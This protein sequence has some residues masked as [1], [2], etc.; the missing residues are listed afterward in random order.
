MCIRD[1]NQTLITASNS[2]T[3]KGDIT[4]EIWK[5]LYHNAPYLLKTKGT[6]RNI[7][8]LL[9]TYGLPST[10]L[11]VFEYGG[12]E[13]DKTKTSYANFD[14]FSHALDF[15]NDAYLKL[16]FEKIDTTHPFVSVGTTKRHPDVLEM[17]FN[18]SNKNKQYLFSRQ[19]KFGVCIEP[20]TSA[21][22][23]DSGYYNHAKIAVYTKDTAAGTHAATSSYL[24]IYDDDWWNFSLNRGAHKALT[25]DANTFNFYCGKAADHSK[26]RIT[27]EATWSYTYASPAQGYE[28]NAAPKVLFIGGDTG[29]TIQG[30]AGRYTGSI[31]EI[32]FYMLPE[33]DVVYSY[34]STNVITRNHVKNPLSIESYG[35]T[36]SY[37]QL[38]GRWSLGTDMNKFSGSWKSGNMGTA[39]MS[40]SHPNNKTSY[41]QNN[42]VSTATP[43]GFAG[44]DS[45][46]TNEEERY[47]VAMPG[48]IGSREIGDKIRIADAAIPSVLSPDFKLY[49]KDTEI[50]DVN[51]IG[52]YFAPHFEIDIDIA[53]DLGGSAVDDY[54]GNPLDIGEGSYAGLRAL[55]QH[56]WK[57]HSAPYSFFDYMNV[58]KQLDHTMFKQIETMLP[59]RA[60]AQVGLLIKGNML[61]RPKIPSL[62]IINVDRSDQNSPRQSTDVFGFLSLRRVHLKSALTTVGGDFFKP[63]KDGKIDYNLAPGMEG[64]GPQ[65]VHMNYL[66][67]NT[68]QAVGF[69]NIPLDTRKS[70]GGY[71][72]GN[73]GSRYKWETVV[74]WTNAAGGTGR[75]KSHVQQG[76]ASY[77]NNEAF[78]VNVRSAGYIGNP[79]AVF[80][81]GGPS[82]S[83]DL[84]AR[85]GSVLTRPSGEVVP[86]F[87]DFG[88]ISYYHHARTSR[89]YSKYAY[90]YK[91]DQQNLYNTNVTIHTASTAENG[92]PSGSV[93]YTSTVLPVRKTIVAAQVQDNRSIGSENRSYRGCK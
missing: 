21:S 46:W 74:Y 42:V 88:N 47:Y 67:D 37:E 58:L 39:I 70:Y 75:T 36:G 35:A 82:S 85:S 6:D 69:L 32:K 57:K 31:Q 93:I 91:S 9:T 7:K 4:K 5:R 81:G 51:K 11:R 22:N 43:Y 89:K 19:N 24:P 17:R 90:H 44:S 54:M 23:L 61:D 3:P 16:P 84:S 63:I 64:S 40:S 78:L 76:G 48:A 59:A 53:N 73:K 25:T 71:D 27:H 55:R 68:D 14:K 45:D 2:S 20:H 72:F 66:K 33:N 62:R 77:E 50:L 92:W 10:L 13:K 86:S 29:S 26:G 83:A 12:P 80:Y 87:N 49:K 15:K 28:S 79:D 1:R 8:A 41:F 30:S 38:I 60:N 18:T 56:Y 34:W 65:Q 52:V